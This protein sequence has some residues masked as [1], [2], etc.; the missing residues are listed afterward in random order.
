ML[1]GK[2]RVRTQDLGYQSGALSPPCYT[3]GKRNGM[4]YYTMEQRSSKD[5]DDYYNNDVVHDNDNIMVMV[6]MIM[7]YSWPYYQQ[8]PCS[9]I[10]LEFKL[11]LDII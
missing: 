10:S 8:G 7:S 11:E 9:V 2:G 5:D 3:P 6:I 4:Y 1:C